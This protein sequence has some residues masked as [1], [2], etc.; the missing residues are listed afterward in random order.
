[1]KARATGER[2]EDFRKQTPP[3]YQYLFE[4]LFQNI[5]IYDNRAV[6]ADYV[7]QAD[8]K[9][10]VKI[11]VEAK[12]YRADGKGQ[13]HLIPLHDMIDVGVLDADGK[14]LYLQKQKIDQEH[15]DFTVTVASGVMVPSALKV[16]STSP[17]RAVSIATGTGA[18]AP[19]WRPW[20]DSAGRPC[21]ARSATRS[22]RSREEASMG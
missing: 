10:Q 9:Y 14:F 4:D 2:R 6:S 1:M 3:Q 11:S 12:K 15:Q 20:P 13:E 17:L 19:E 18:L 16:M 22:Q 5:T 7:K 8:G 21:T